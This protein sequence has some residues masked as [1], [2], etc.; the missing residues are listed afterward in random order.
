VALLVLVAEL[1]QGLEQLAE[2]ID[3]ADESIEK[4]AREN[5]ACRRLV[6]MPESALFQ[7]DGIFKTFPLASPA[8]GTIGEDD[9]VI[10]RTDHDV[11][12]W[13]AIPRPLPT[14]GISTLQH[15]IPLQSPHVQLD[16]IGR[17]A[18]GTP[19]FTASPA[20]HSASDLSKSIGNLDFMS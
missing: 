13:L 9:P 16:V 10:F 14:E 20:A 7:F 2:K 19:S 12:G 18:L 5:E 8:A 4:I 15:G 11:S 6:T 17:C 1:K 3:S